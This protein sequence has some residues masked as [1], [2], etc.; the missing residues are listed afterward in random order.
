MSLHQLSPMAQ[1]PTCD[2]GYIRRALGKTRMSE[3]TFISFVQ[4]LVDERGFPRPLP[5]YRRGALVDRVTRHS[6]FHR[7]SVDCWLDNFVP[8]EAATAQQAAASLAAATEMDAAACNLRLIRGG[9][10]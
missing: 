1:A 8:P 7:A 10:V 4:A 9:R 6:S 5:D 3:R 2:L